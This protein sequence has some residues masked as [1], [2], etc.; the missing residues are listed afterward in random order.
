MFPGHKS[1]E[2]R[3]RMTGGRQEENGWAFSSL[4]QNVSDVITILEADG[5]VRYVSPAVETALGYRLEELIGNRIFSLVHPDDLERASRIFGEIMSKPETPH[6]DSSGSLS[7]G[8]RMARV[9]CE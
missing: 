1:G 3:Q 8:R 5:T 7:P 9:A 2:A 4:V 6:L